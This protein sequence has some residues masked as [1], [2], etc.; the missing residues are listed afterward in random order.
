MINSIQYPPTTMSKKTTYT[1]D[2]IAK[3]LDISKKSAYA[4]IKMGKFHYVK[5]GRMIRVSKISFDRWL[6]Q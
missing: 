2:E 4:L 5:V 3:Q 1:V 6:N